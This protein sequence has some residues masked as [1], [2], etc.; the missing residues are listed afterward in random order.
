MEPAAVE[1]T[2]RMRQ[3]I[4][5]YRITQLVHAAAHFGIADILAQGPATAAEVAAR[6]GTDAD[7][8]F[9][10]LRACAA[11]ELV[12][13][14]S[15][16]RFASTALLDTLRRDA[17]GL[18]RNFANCHGSP[19]FWL[20]WGRFIHSVK[21]GSQQATAA[22]GADM[23][24]YYR[25]NPEEAAEFSATMSGWTA[26]VSKETVEI[27]DT[28]SFAVAADIGGSGGALLHALMKAN[29][30]LRGILFDLPE[31]TATASANS[32]WH[33]MRERLSVV[34]GN[35]LAEVP[36]ADVYFLKYILHDWDST[37]CVRILKNCRRSLRP[38]GRVVVIDQQ[39]GEINQPGP[40]PLIDL[41]MLVLLSGARERTLAEYEA[42]H[43]AADLRI[44]KVTPTLSGM[45][46]MQAVAV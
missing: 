13:A 46:V 22:H 11:L 25:N 44:E 18:L 4:L 26:T 31:V 38:G 6:C 27:V 30:R 37:S 45:A 16:L 5:G 19:G 7:A 23:W 29:P 42:L 21:T 15:E 14:D 10:L 39:L 20:P 41:T 40:A 12:I 32:Q 33:G 24:E 2:E 36:P 8:T 3:M 9:R 34:G 28:H 43:A 1:N 17:P 35:F